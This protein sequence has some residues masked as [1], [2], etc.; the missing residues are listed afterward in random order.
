VLV[1]SQWLGLLETV[2]EQPDRL[3]IIDHHERIEASR[4]ADFRDIRTSAAATA[5][6]AAG[7]LHDQGITPSRSLA[8]AIIY[9]IDTETDG[10]EVHHSQ[11]DRAIVRW[12][13]EWADPETLAAIQN[14]PL[15]RDYF[16]DLVLALQNTFLY[17]DAAVCIMPRAG[18][19]EITGELA[20]LLIRTDGVERVLC[21][22]GVGEDVVVSARAGQEDGAALVRATLEGLGYGGGHRHRAGGKIGN[23]LKDGAIPQRLAEQLRKRW[24]RACGLSGQPGQ[25]LVSKREIV[26]NLR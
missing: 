4:G 3:A 10:P 15:S 14:A 20:D 12:A 18:R 13:T 19:A 6:I 11:L 22:A 5:S 23:A 21:A 25:R 17:Q 26:R 16:G 7:Y 1:D 8:T 24:L 9:A 2:S